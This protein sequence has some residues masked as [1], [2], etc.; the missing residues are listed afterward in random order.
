VPGSTTRSA[1]ER[2]STRRARGSLSE[3]EI[4][5]AA[6]ALVTEAGLDGLSM[7]ALARRLE[8][9]VTSIYWY[10]RSKD[11]LLVALTERVTTAVHAQLPPLGS[12]PWHEVL[13]DHLLALRQLLEDQPRYREVLARSFT[14]GPAAHALLAEPGAAAAL[15][16]AAGA[17]PAVAAEVVEI[18]AGFTR[19]FVVLEHRLESEVTDGHTADRLRHVEAGDYPN[20]G[21]FPDFVEAMWLDHEQC[22]FG[23]RLLVAGLRAEHGI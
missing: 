7:P 17:S 18:V 9:G 23:L 11:E 4:L 2:T 21:Q 13:V 5:D 20:L 15:V 6:L 3:T 12:G 8:S 14:I 16:V 1:P 19:G 22:R 10:F